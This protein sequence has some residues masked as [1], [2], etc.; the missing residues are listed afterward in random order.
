MAMVDAT[1][2]KQHQRVLKDILPSKRAFW[3]LLP[4]DI[5]AELSDAASEAAS[6][7]R[8]ILHKWASAEQNRLLASYI[9]SFFEP[10][11][12]RLEQRMTE[13]MMELTNPISYL[14]S[15]GLT[16][17]F[18]Q[19]DERAVWLAGVVPIAVW[20]RLVKDPIFREKFFRAVNSLMGEK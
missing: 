18:A 11:L 19:L 14:A 12:L 8:V 10:K 9:I 2:K 13:K 3:E 15:V 4:D 1:S 5:R 7:M 17:N 6:L 16:L 20:C